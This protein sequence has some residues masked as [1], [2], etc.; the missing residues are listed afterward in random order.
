MM[1]INEV[2]RADGT[3][4]EQLVESRER[5]YFLFRKL[6]LVSAAARDL[7]DSPEAT[8]LSNEL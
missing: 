3:L 2:K 1:S 4:I 5:R 8:N 6:I 7:R